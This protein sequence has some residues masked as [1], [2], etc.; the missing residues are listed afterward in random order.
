[1]I[2]WQPTGAPPMLPVL[3]ITIACGACSGFHCLVA[4]GTT[5]KQVNAERD[6]RPV[7]YGSMLTEGFLATLV[8][9]ACAAGLGLSSGAAKITFGPISNDPPFFSFGVQTDT[10]TYGVKEHHEWRDGQS[11]RRYEPEHSGATT[12]VKQWRDSISWEEMQQMRPHP[13]RYSGDLNFAL[14]YSSWSS[15]SGLANTVGAFVEGA[16][17]FLRAIGIP[18]QVAI[19]LMAVMVASFAATTLD[20]AC[21]LQRYVIQEFASTFLP[22]R[23]GASCPACGYDLSNTAP[24]TD[25]TYACP[26]CGKTNTH[27]DVMTPTRAVRCRVASPLN[28]FKWLATT[29][30]ATL[31]A[32]ITAFLLALGPWPDALPTPPAG[33]INLTGGTLT[34]TL[35]VSAP[36]S[37]LDQ[38]KQWLTTGGSGGMILWPLFGATN[39]LLAGFAFIV[40][41]AWLIARKKPIWFLIIPALFM[42]AVPASAMTWQAFIGNTD[43]PSWWSQD[44]M[45]LVSVAT[46]TLVLEAWL[47][48]EVFIRWRKGAA[49][50]LAD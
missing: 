8:I 28:P 35:P 37:F 24:N 16:A 29:H 31:F 46:I 15:S 41:A 26:E 42:L 39:Q 49:R 34:G 19:A 14:R 11:H 1:M 33:A 21:R 18:L 6:A 20:T 2:D 32:V 22:K 48:I 10:G 40:I 13:I 47:L 5:S 44:N 36:P 23:K 45:L 12:L 17:N 43:N 27:N 9:A 30:G 3:F 7:A 50:M 38:A 25:N 4:S